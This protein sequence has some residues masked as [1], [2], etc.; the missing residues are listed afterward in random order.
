M[1]LETLTTELQ[2]RL[3][4]AMTDPQTQPGIPVTIIDRPGFRAE[5][6]FKVATPPPLLERLHEMG[7]RIPSN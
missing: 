5:V 3:M 7:Y 4:E 2:D 1:T 6:T